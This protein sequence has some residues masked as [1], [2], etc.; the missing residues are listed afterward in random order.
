M[1]SPS[2]AAMHKPKCTHRLFRR[3]S[4]A[5][6]WRAVDPASRTAT[7]NFRLGRLSHQRFDFLSARGRE[8]VACAMNGADLDAMRAQLFAHLANHDVQDFRVGFLVRP[9]G[10]EHGHHLILGRSMAP[11]QQPEQHALAVGQL[12]DLDNFLRLHPRL[13]PR[14]W[15]RAHRARPQPRASTQRVRSSLS[16]WHAVVIVTPHNSHKHS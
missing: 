16:P 3:K 12:S 10:I 8:L 9:I 15:P 11:H 14:A 2:R 6:S 7:M 13:A 1:R 4:L 5:G